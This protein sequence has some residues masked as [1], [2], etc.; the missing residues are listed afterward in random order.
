MSRRTN[1]RSRLERR[2]ERESNDPA[3]TPRARRTRR[4]RQPVGGGGGGIST[5]MVAAVAGG[6]FLVA[7]LVYAV[8]QAG[9][10]GDGIPDW[11]KAE[12]NDDTSLPGMYIAPHAG[13]DG[14]P[15]TQDDRQ[16]RNPGVIIP[17][18]TDEQMESGNVTDPLC[19]TS[20]P[21]VSGPHSL[22]PQ[23]FENME[24]PAPKENVVHSM[25][26]GGIYIWYNTDDQEAI[27]LIKS[28]VNDNGDRNR[29][30]GSTIYEDME[31]DTIAVTAWTRLDKFPVSELTRDR[32][33][34]FV[35]EHH[36][37]FNPEGF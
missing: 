1:S 18:C 22:T 30:V 13:P 10:T 17:I 26:H 12:L 35:N 28:V 34:D 31:E 4:E 25:E 32:I 21:P 37:R 2:A 11:R 5:T 7:I 36:K 14:V 15:E 20:N 9:S 29:F 24:N 19:Y 33:Q 6:L 16:H 3:S 23:G 8:V 27:D